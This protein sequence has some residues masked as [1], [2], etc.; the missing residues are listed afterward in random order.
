VRD[1]AQVSGVGEH[2]AHDT[3]IRLLATA[4]ASCITN[5]WLFCDALAGEQFGARSTNIPD[6][7]GSDLRR[8][9]RHAYG[10]ER[11]HALLDAG[12]LHINI[13]GTSDCGVFTLVAVARV[14]ETASAMAGSHKGIALA[15]SVVCD[16]RGPK[17]GVDGGS[18]SRA[19]VAGWLMAQP[20]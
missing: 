12:C 13:P 19:A 9:V 18:G 17:A 4:R 7:Y 8:R 2:V 16:S 1:P 3:S 5:S 10:V 15:R 6:R 14:V 20:V 11:C